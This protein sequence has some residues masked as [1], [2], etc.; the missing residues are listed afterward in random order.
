MS[1]Q[2][3]KVITLDTIPDE[4]WA[5]KLAN[6]DIFWFMGIYLP[7]QFSANHAKKYT[8]RKYHNI[9]KSKYMNP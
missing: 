2:Y 7:S 8:V 9:R 6:Y 4:A 3:Q 5:E 1:Q